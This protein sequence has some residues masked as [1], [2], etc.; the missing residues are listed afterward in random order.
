[1]KSQFKI[2]IKNKSVNFT[3]NEKTKT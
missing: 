3:Q 2:T 1:M